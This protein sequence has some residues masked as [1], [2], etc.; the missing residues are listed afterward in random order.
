M[1]EGLGSFCEKTKDCKIENS[2]CTSRNTCECK[3]NFVAQNESECKPSYGVEC[4]ATEDCAF[5]NAECKVE[6][7]DEVKPTKKCRC[8]DDF[9]EVERACLVKGFYVN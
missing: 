9:V 6:L 2:A 8:K 7:V 3:P 1:Q 5:E 4:E